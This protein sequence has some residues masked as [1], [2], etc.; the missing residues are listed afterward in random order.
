ML[1]QLCLFAFC[2]LGFTV[3]QG[4]KE[5][6]YTYRDLRAARVHGDLFERSLATTLRKSIELV[7]AEG[8]LVTS[9][10]SKLCNSQG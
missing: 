10:S 2:L 6:D 5:S 1:V 7:Y 4:G 9:I 3:A 8:M